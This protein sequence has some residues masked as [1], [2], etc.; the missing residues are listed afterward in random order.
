M[1]QQVLRDIELFE[2]AVEISM[3]ERR[4]LDGVC[5]IVIA[6]TGN[7][8]RLFIGSDVPDML[9]PLLADVFDKAPM[10]SNLTL[11]PAAISAVR[12]LLAPAC[13]P[14]SLHASL[15]YVV[16][17]P[18]RVQ[19]RMGIVR[20][21]SGEAPSLTNLNPGNWAS[22]EWQELLDGVLGP[23]AMALADGLVV[24]IC[25]TPGPMTDRA[26]EC[27]VWTHPDYRGRGHAAEV[28]AV[29]AGTLRPS[30]RLLSLQH[31]R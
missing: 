30:G 12:E 13:S 17:P 11:E 7:E 16:E 22:G 3:D 1:G 20:S 10:P 2:V 24:S 21:D 5:G 18:R 8:S 9:V 31:A 25:H 26:A 14:L 29:L 19:I 6:T 28:T 27:G 15:Y 23:W 4:R